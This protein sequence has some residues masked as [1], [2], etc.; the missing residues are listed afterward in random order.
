MK[1]KF[2][3]INWRVA[4]TVCCIS[5]VIETKIMSTAKTS[6]RIRVYSGNH[7]AQYYPVGKNVSLE[8]N[9]LLK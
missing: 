7:L 9:S 8:Q 3:E 2:E 5:T 1:G 6:F 4:W